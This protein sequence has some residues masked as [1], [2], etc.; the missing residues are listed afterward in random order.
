MN[1]KSSKQQGEVDSN[2]THF[3]C[4]SAYCTVS[5]FQEV[6][7][8]EEKSAMQHSNNNNDDNII[9]IL[10]ATTKD[11]IQL[12]KTSIEIISIK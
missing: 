6:N 9:I 4:P 12:K 5:H 10:E 3:L 8:W 2:C 7:S 1:I 11:K